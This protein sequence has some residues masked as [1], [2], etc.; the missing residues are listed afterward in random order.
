MRHGNHPAVLCGRGSV[1]C[2]CRRQTSA[3]RVRSWPVSTLR[4][5]L[6]P[7]GRLWRIDVPRGRAT[8]THRVQLLVRAGPRAPMA[9]SDSRNR[10]TVRFLSSGAPLGLLRGTRGLRLHVRSTLPARRQF[11][12]RL[13]T[14]RHR[15]TTVTLGLLVAP[16]AILR[17]DRQGLRNKGRSYQLSR[18]AR[19]LPRFGQIWPIGRV[20]LDERPRSERRRHAVHRLRIW[21]TR[22]AAST[23]NGLCLR[24]P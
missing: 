11:L 20:P 2:C 16:A 13:G 17:L 24:F 21:G 15:E 19:R 3:S 9:W 5:P 22:R 6:R 18:P 10:R 1:Q 12:Y 8:G 14:D 7:L 23:D 4:D